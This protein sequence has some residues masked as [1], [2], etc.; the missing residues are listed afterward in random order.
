MD[1]HGERRADRDVDALYV[2]MRTRHGGASVRANGYRLQSWFAS[3]QAMILAAVAATAGPVV[4]IGCGSGLMVKPLVG[5][6]RN[7][8][9]IDFNRQACADARANRIP[10]VR[11]DAYALPLADAS[12]GCIVNCQFLNQQSIDRAAP[13]I[14]EIARVLRPAGRAVIVWRNGTALI[15]RAARAAF[16]MVDQF[17]GRP[18][19]PY[20]NHQVATLVAHARAHELVIDSSGVVFPPPRWNL[21]N[22]RSLLARLIGASG[23]LIL[24]RPSADGTD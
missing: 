8:L 14:A 18:E 5:H 1:H 3:E 23:L 4:D 16:R 17:T 20:V 2:K 15:H 11:G 21:E 6:G 13:L 19:F 7:V 24:T 22:E 12:I 10:V 9:G